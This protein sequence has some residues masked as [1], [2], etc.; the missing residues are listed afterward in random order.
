[1]NTRV[2]STVKNRSPRVSATASARI[3][4]EIVYPGHRPAPGAGVLASSACIPTYVSVSERSP[5]ECWKDDT[6]IQ[7]KVVDVT[8]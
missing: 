4:H 2:K 5:L 8:V 6:Y 7:L 1:M 3:A